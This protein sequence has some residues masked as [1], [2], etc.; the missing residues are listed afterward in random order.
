MRCKK[1]IL[2]MVL[3]MFVGL[4]LWGCTP[5]QTEE[6]KP[7][8]LSYFRHKLM[9][10]A[11]ADPQRG[12]AA[13][14][15]GQILTT[16][17]GGKTWVPQKSG[18]THTLRASS[19][20]DAKRGWMVGGAGTIIRTEDGGLSWKA[21]NSGTKDDLMCVKFLDDKR[22]FAAGAFSLF[23]RTEDGGLTWT[24]LTSQ[25]SEEEVSEVD[26]ANM[27]AEEKMN[28]LKEEFAAEGGGEEG[29]SVI[30]LNPMINEIVFIS[31]VK[32]WAVGE[33]G[34]IWTTNDG[35]LKW[36]KQQSGQLE[37]L[38]SVFFKN[39]DEGWASGLNGTL[40]YTDNGGK[41]WKPQATT[42][43]QSLFGIA[44]SGDRG[45]AVGNAATMLE[46]KDGGKTWKEFK[47]ASIQNFSW[48]R[49]VV[50]VK[51]VQDKYV[52]VGGLG[53][54]MISKDGG[55]NWEKIS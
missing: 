21:L 13:G 47:P 7:F 38:F 5:K 12:W 42:V 36:V 3:G 40:L 35:G 8:Q 43:V 49:A 27:S 9:T 18:T 2:W 28:A 48:I 25:F 17:D 10:V 45:F 37:D 53:T 41:T 14:D 15:Q 51:D 16:A 33:A 46:T 19:F 1:M 24:D 32:G 31:P 26:T 52:A 55:V 20:I 54:I 6:L 22:G 30:P 11:F 39:E 34:S 4:P 23:L 50:V 44:V 29:E